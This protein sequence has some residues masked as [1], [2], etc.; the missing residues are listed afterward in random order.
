[1]DD[2]RYRYLRSLQRPRSVYL[3]FTYKW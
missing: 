3:S 2:P 1:V